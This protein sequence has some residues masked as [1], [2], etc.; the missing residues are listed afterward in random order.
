MRRIGG[1]VLQVVV[2][3]VGLAFAVP[4]V[5]QAKVV[6][7][8]FGSPTGTLGGE[9][10]GSFPGVLGVAVN[11]S[12]VGAPAGTMYVIHAN[13]GRS[14]VQRLSP[15]GVFERT[16]GQ[17]VIAAGKPGDISP[18]AFE[19]CT[20]ASDCKEAIATGTTA[21]G[22]QLSGAVG[23]VVNPVNG[24]V[25]V[26]E[27][28]NRRVS[29]FDADGNF[30]RL[31]GWDVVM[32][33]GSGDVSTSAFEICTVVSQCKQAAAAGP[34]GGQLGNAIGAPV[35]DASQNVWLPEGGNRRLSRF[36]A[37]GNF[38]ATYGHNVDALGGTGGLESCTS[39]VI[40]ACAAG[41][42]GS[43]PGQFS[44][45]NPRFMAIDAPG[46][47]YAVD[48]SNNR[49]QRFDPLMSSASSFAAATLSTFTASAPEQLVATQGGSSIA[50]AVN[51]QMA[52]ERQIVEVDSAGLLT[53]TALVG[54]GLDNVSALAV[55]VA[56][57][58]LATTTSPARRAAVLLFGDPLPA[59]TTAVEPSTEVGSRQ[60]TFNGVVNPVGAWVQCK[61]QYSTD[62]VSWT[63]VAAPGC[64]SLTHDGGP[65]PIEREVTGLVPS[66]RYH[67]RLVVSRPL[68][69]GS[70]VTSAT[71]T[72]DTA[73]GPPVLVS[74]GAS[75]ATNTS[76]HVS[77]I[78]DTSNASTGWVVE[79]GTTPA[80][81]K[82]TAP[83]EV[84]AGSG[85]A[86]VGQRIDGLALGAKHFFRVVASNPAG[87]ATGAVRSFATEPDELSA[88]RAYEM[89][90]PPEKNGG[91]AMTGQTNAAVA[92]DGD[93]LK[94]MTSASFGDPPAPGSSFYGASYYTAHRT[95]AGWRTKAATPDYCRNNFSGGLNNVNSN[96]LVTYSDNLDQSVLS[97]PE[98]AACP[99]PALDAAAS[100]PQRNLYRQQMVGDPGYQLLTPF[101]QAT[102]SHTAGAAV[103]AFSADFDHLVYTGTGSQ[104]P[105]SPPS[106][107]SRVYEWDSGELRLVSISPAG[108][109][110]TTA[111]TVPAGESIA[112]LGGRPVGPNGINA[113]SD[114]GDRVFFHNGTPQNAYV[115]VDGAKT[116]WVSQSECTASCTGDSQADTLAWA[117]PDGTKAV[118]LSADKLTDNDVSATGAGPDA[119]RYADSAAPATDPGNLVL[120]SRDEE[121][122]DGVGTGTVRIIGIADDGD[123]VFFAATGQ[124]VAGKPTAAGLKIY[125]SRVVAGDAVTDYLGTIGS[126]ANELNRLTDFDRFVTPDGAHLLLS[127]QT[128]LDEGVDHDSF[129][130][131]YK[132]SGGEWACISCQ[133][134]GQPATGH[135]SSGDVE[136]VNDD[137]VGNRRRYSMTDDGRRVVFL[138][139]DAL[140]ADDVNGVNDVYLW[141]AGRLRLITPGQA[142][143][144]NVQLIGS[145]PDG[146]DVFFATDERLVGW[147]TDTAPDIYDARIGG[148]V[149]E[150]EVEPVECSGSGCQ[151]AGAERTRVDEST[152]AT[153]AE[154]GTDGTRPLFTLRKL[155]ARTQRALA[156]GRAVRLAVSTSRG[157]RLTAS[158]VAVWAGKRHRVLSGTATTGKQGVARVRVKLSRAA[159]K[160]LAS[161]RRLRVTVTV[162]FAGA[163]RP[164]TGTLTLKRPRPAARLGAAR[165]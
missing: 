25:Y 53:D 5:S 142:S 83:L 59:P 85:Q 29:E 89:V 30:V 118:V 160:R 75:Q 159:L 22:G 91:G 122:A 1:A 21:N 116:H 55:D 42:Q 41:T 158:G 153:P 79:Y 50:F 6:V 107:V 12:G 81:G 117:T 39:T 145:T 144:G 54:A 112:R 150:P 18:T 101:P 134:P 71:R 62:K 63:D 106:G 119:Y 120:L 48:A 129:V 126:S 148:G 151:D 3:V 132:W 140:V 17:D 77:A 60:V 10:G 31:W 130:D 108:V 146:R 105:D 86:T 69:P 58:L 27:S 125:R 66:T 137:A 115:R 76:V 136:V 43:A 113:M 82:S 68:D 165:G 28:S 34:N 4:A 78:I 61:F 47:V 156:N 32:T 127:T 49:V 9:F 92:I 94:F 162:R 110:F 155:G 163:A 139:S 19:I 67:V 121:P 135:A 38:V 37:S 23:L 149:P 131:L 52:G 111:S 98:H 97:Q 138:T 33:G 24:H 109:P 16:W 157:G 15:S 100:M 8:G 26:T 133:L 154:T 40:G 164:A 87:S 7:G 56:G 104:T 161:G 128:K 147:D 141:E 2:V 93:A 14:R 74:Q 95:P 102:Q 80:L 114:A 35:L 103:E 99:F 51:N 72:F 143:D 44:L 45:N 57:N 84:A 13:S 64:E 65:Q 36:D 70:V 11:S 73:D 96:Q 20:V 46:N 124:L 88:V 90:S 152:S 123:T